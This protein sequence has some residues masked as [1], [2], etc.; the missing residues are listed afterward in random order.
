M[1]TQRIEI[2]LDEIDKF[3]SIDLIETQVNSLE[4]TKLLS[5]DKEIIDVF[6]EALRK[7]KQGDNVV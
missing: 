5:Q 4:L 3:V 6:N 1:A 7:R 2:K